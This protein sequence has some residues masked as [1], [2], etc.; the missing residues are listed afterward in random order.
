[1]QYHPGSFSKNIGWSSED[2]VGLGK[3]HKI[4][5]AGF[6][7][8]LAPV[9][10]EL[11]RKNCGLDADRSLIPVNYFLHN[12]GGMISVDELVFRSVHGQLDRQFS[13]LGLFALHLSAT[14]SSRPNTPP[15]AGWANEYIRQRVGEDGRW[16]SGVLETK[17]IEHFLR[18]K[19]Q[20]EA[21][22]VRKCSTNYQKIIEL[23]EF[24]KSEAGW[25]DTRFEEWMVPALFLAWDRHILDQ[26][27]SPDRNDLISLVDKNELYKLMGAPST[28]KTSLGDIAD[29]Y[30][31]SGA[32]DRFDKEQL[33]E[34]AI[35]DFEILK[36]R[37][38]DVAIERTL[39]LRSEQQRSKAHV[40]RLKKVYDNECMFCQTKL[41][42][43][44]NQYYSEA[45]HI[46]PL[47]Q[48]H[49]GPDRP[50]NMLI[51][52]MNHHLQFDRGMLS[53]QLSGSSF[54]IV[55]A[56]N[57]DP[58][59]GRVLEPKHELDHNCVA[60]HHKQIYQER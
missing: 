48:P 33:Q 3:L 6:T 46:R 37:Q 40:A 34:T 38:H 49:N 8:K 21:S 45:A 51:L 58:L 15:S 36:G 1:M 44:P 5:N 7:G 22:V 18:L 27:I 53:V 28:I 39:V 9:K 29:L 13:F 52:C 26:D 4:I 30:I 57:G 2:D 50:Y 59:S 23:C 43:G 12:K 32:I 16:R 55:S 41:Q 10:R 42:V 14:G 20:A 47:G 17:L 60:W 54:Q 35:Q 56:I 31:E 25:L 24:K 11:F 19:L